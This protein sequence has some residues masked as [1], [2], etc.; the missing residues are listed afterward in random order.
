MFGY[1]VPYSYSLFLACRCM[2]YI[3][4]IS[5]LDLLKFVG[6]EG[7]ILNA[8]NVSIKRYFIGSK[9]GKELDGNAVTGQD[10]MVYIDNNQV[11]YTDFASATVSS[12][13]NGATNTPSSDHI[14][15]QEK[16]THFQF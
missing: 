8:D 6:L 13:G 2:I 10:D 5:A 3:L 9:R 1:T 4:D 16:P 14:P 7:Q 12:T 11:E 15:D